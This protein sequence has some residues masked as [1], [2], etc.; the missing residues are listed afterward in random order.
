M[1]FRD[2]D[3]TE[4]LIKFEPDVFEHAFFE[5]SDRNGA[6]DVFST[7]RAERMMLIGSLLEDP[8]GERYFGWDKKTKSDSLDRC[9]LVH[10][11][12]DFVVVVRFFLSQRGEIRGRFVTCYVADAAQT[13]PK[14]RNH[15]RWEFD[16]LKARLL[17]EKTKRR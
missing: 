17:E 10:N 9:V 13:L 3:G 12:F 6:D 11:N 7:K 2:R 8:F 4:I 14:I 5:S 15:A 1:F 16:T